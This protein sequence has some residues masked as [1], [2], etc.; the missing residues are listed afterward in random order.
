MILERW[1]LPLSEA[2]GLVPKTI[3][4]AARTDIACASCEMCSSHIGLDSL[5]M[6]PPLKDMYI[7]NVCN[8]TYSWQC[9]LETNCYNTIEREAIDT[10][11]H[12]PAQPV[13][14]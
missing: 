8:C 5:D 7:C 2:V 10:N 1:A 13:F 14:T 12:G 6:L 11:T 3:Q 9:L 4:A